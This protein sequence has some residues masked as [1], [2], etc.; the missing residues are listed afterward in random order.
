MLRKTIRYYENGLTFA[1]GMGTASSYFFSANGCFDPNVTGTGHQPMWFDQAMLSFEQYTVVAS[2]LRATCC[3]T[4]TTMFPRS[5]VYLSPDTTSITDPIRLME[6]GLITTKIH[7]TYSGTDG[8]K[9]H[10][11]LGCDIA[12]YF[13]RNQSPHELVTDVTLSGTSAANPTEQVYFGIVCWDTQAAATA[14]IYFEVEIL[15]DV[16]F[17]EPRK[18]TVS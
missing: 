5:G 9:V 3:Q 10:H 15:Y 14:G 6:N 7:S 4:S 17:W 16:I 18:L 1:T 2:K 8:F 11:E 13:G 12:A